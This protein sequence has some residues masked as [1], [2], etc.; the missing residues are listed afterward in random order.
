MQVLL[1]DDP[2][3]MVNLKFSNACESCKYS[4]SNLNSGKVK[5]VETT[6]GVT[7]IVIDEI[8]R[9][10]TVKATL[11]GNDSYGFSDGG[12]EIS[13]DPSLYQI[14][15]PSISYGYGSDPRTSVVITFRD[16][17]TTC[18]YSV[19][20]LTGGVISKAEKVKDQ[21]SITISNISRNS[22]FKATLIGSDAYGFSDSGQEISEDVQVSVCDNS[23]CY[24]GM[25]W[26]VNTGYWPSGTG[27]MS[28]QELVKG[29]W[30]TVKTTKPIAAKNNLPIYPNTFAIT[31]KNV[32][33]GKRT[34]RLSI[35]AKG[36]YSVYVGKSF[37]Q[38]VKP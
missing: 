23:F 38:V 25:D 17:C 37:T 30:V 5:S 7:T 1:G 10:Q 11:T 32:S 22:G 15:P 33:A 4:L 21:N 14:L 13:A 18:T 8:N 19:V 36:K 26:V 24:Q 27:S 12:Q 2:Y 35:S 9:N 29:K 3:T 34:Y 6:N 16:A 31:I 20:G 28:L